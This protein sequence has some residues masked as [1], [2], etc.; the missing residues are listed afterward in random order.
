MNVK[1]DRMNVNH[2]R[3]LVK[4]ASKNVNLV[5]KK[6]NQIRVNVNLE[7][8]P[9]NLIIVSDNPPILT[10]KKDPLWNKN[11]QAHFAGAKRQQHLQKELV[12][13]TIISSASNI[14]QLV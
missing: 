12:P 14:H 3:I 5:S 4:K 10:H 9:V 8:K 7:R 2:V 6:V 11:L 13:S 1:N